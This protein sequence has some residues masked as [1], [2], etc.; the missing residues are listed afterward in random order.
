MGEIDFCEW[1]RRGRGFLYNFLAP[2]V[3]AEQPAINCFGVRSTPQQQARAAATTRQRYSARRVHTTC[4]RARLLA[5]NG[6][7]V[8]HMYVAVFQWSGRSSEELA[9]VVDKRFVPTPA[10]AQDCQTR[11]SAVTQPITATDTF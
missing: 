10:G 9:P 7:E 6:G 4:M 11:L 1:C 2:R 8:A 5:T 3:R